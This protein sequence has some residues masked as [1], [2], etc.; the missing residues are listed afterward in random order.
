MRIVFHLF[1]LKD[2]SFK[3]VYFRRWD[4]RKPIFCKNRKYAKEYWTKNI[5]NE[6]IEKLN[7]AESPIARTL[8][9]RLDAES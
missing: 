1:D 6:D 3:K 5:A 9:V 7:R 8:A 4:G 2:N